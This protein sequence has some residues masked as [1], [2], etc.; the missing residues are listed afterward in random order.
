MSATADLQ[1]A[2]RVVHQP[3]ARDHAVPELE[4]LGEATSTAGKLGI[5]EACGG[6]RCSD[7]LE[8]LEVAKGS[9]EAEDPFAEQ[10]GTDAMSGDW[11]F[12]Y[13][14]RMQDC[15]ESIDVEL[16]DATP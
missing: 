2:L 9:D 5:V 13:E 14:L 1:I 7:E 15:P 12:E 10:L 6:S 3:Q 8:H 4:E 11:S 16:I